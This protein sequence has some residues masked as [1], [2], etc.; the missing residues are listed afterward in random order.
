MSDI[1][2]FKLIIFLK[3]TFN[4]SIKNIEKN[5]NLNYIYI[6]IISNIYIICK[7]F[8]IISFLFFIIS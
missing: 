6:K 1:F 2:K 4:M 7:S 3:Y 5:P 8:Y